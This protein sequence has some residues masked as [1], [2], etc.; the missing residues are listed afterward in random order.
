MYIH[1]CVCGCVYGLV[2]FDV[3]QARAGLFVADNLVR[4]P[5]VTNNR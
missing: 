2:R 5:A 3:F 4:L 1:V